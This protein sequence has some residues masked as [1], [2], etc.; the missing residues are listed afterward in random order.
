M[1][2][3]EP[4]GDHITPG[5]LAVIFVALLALLFF[6]IW[7]AFKDLG[8]MNFVVGM[9]IALCKALLVLYYFMQ[10]KRS[11]RLVWMYAGAGL[12][13]LFIGLILVLC[14]YFTR[15]PGQVG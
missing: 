13:W 4:H 8:T 6:S 11:H 1:E 15:A 3:A 7:V 12:I 14:D 10:V 2:I 9:L 5:T